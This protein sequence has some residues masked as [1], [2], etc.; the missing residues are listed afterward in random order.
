M[1]TVVGEDDR[2]A[3]SALDYAAGSL[4]AASVQAAVQLVH[5]CQKSKTQADFELFNL[6]NISNK[7]YPWCTGV[8]CILMRPTLPP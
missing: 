8:A 2:G 7:V 4:H 5:F 1:S 6:E 3:I